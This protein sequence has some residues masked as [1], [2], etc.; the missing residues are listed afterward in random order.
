MCCFRI[1]PDLF[2]AERDAAMA[3]CAARR[4]G[5]GCCQGSSRPNPP[6]AE[7][8]AANEIEVLEAE[9]S[10]D[11]AEA[12]LEVA[13]ANSR[14]S[15]SR[16]TTPRCGRRSR[17]RSKPGRPTSGASWAASDRVCSPGSTT[18]S[19]VHVWMTVPD[20]LFLQTGASKHVAQSGGELAYPIEI[21]TESRRG[22]SRTPA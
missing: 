20:R 8:G 12:D 13:S 15:S 1:D 21:A 22:L 4:G 17:A 7:R 9:A 19:S 16:L 3:A 2:A 14:S 11:T 5:T 6:A 10:V 18:T